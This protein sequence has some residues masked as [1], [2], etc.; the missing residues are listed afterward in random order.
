MDKRIIVI[1]SISDK[2]YFKNIFNEQT[3]KIM[4]IPKMPKCD[5]IHIGATLGGE[6]GENILD[7]LL[8]VD[9]LHEITSFDEKRLNNIGYHRIGHDTDKGVIKY[10]KIIDFFTMDYDVIVYVVQKDTKVYRE[11]LLFESLLTNN[12]EVRESYKNFKKNYLQKDVLFKNYQLEK[13]QFIKEI[14][15]K[16]DRND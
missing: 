14:L 9:N 15:K 12:E 3:R 8:V 7:I 11:F 13:K 6:I 16:E 4:S 1:D 10:A 5:F 2:N